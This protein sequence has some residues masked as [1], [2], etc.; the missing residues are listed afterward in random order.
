MRRE[1]PRGGGAAIV[2]LATLAP[3][4]IDAWQYRTP[5]GSHPN[6]ANLLSWWPFEE[7]S[8]GTLQDFWTFMPTVLSGT[9]Q[10]WSPST[11][12]S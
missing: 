1:R 11:V 7:G 3:A 2:S 10:S 4:T 12:R 8:G 5:D 6:A 9:G